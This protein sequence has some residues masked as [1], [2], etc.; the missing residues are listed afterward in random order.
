MISAAEIRLERLK[1][2]KEEEIAR[3]KREEEWAKFKPIYIQEE[4]TKQLGEIERE[5]IEKNKRNKNNVEFCIHNTH[6]IGKGVEEILKKSGYI[7]E[8][9]H[10][11]S[12]NVRFYGD[13]E[14]ETD[15]DS[16]CNIPS[17]SL[18]ISW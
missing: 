11:F 10:R 2:E 12:H 9:E 3:L 18:K 4:I 5:I 13:G 8:A 7:V 6:E 1:R 17:S 16:P 14:Y 15:F